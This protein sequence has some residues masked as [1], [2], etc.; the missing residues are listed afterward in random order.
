[1]FVLG[2]TCEHTGTLQA[3]ITLHS[4]PPFLHSPY[5]PPPPPSRRAVWAGCSFFSKEKKTVDYFCLPF[6]A[7]HL[8]WQ[9][10]LNSHKRFIVLQLQQNLTDCKQFTAVVPQISTGWRYNT[11][12]HN[13]GSRSQIRIWLICLPPPTPTPQKNTFS[14]LTYIQQLNFFKAIKRQQHSLWH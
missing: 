6:F 9:V 2:F 4:S 7:Q 5:Y 1:M 8:A 3:P 14:T 10:H 12:K 13:F 11:V